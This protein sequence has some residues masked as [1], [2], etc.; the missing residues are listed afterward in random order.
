MQSLAEFL[1]IDIRS[2]LKTLLVKGSDDPVVALVLRGDHELNEIKAAALPDVMAPLTFATEDELRTIAG[3][4]P[5]SIGPVTLTVPVIADRS[6][7]VLSN[8][9][10][11]ANED[12][13]HLINVNWGRDVDEP[14]VAD[15]RNVVEGDPSPCGS[16][17]LNIVRG[18]EVGH[19]FELGLTYSEAMAATILD[20]NGKSVA[21]HMGCYGIGIGRIVAAAIEQNHDQAGIIWPNALSPFEV[22]I[23]PIHMQKSPE[24]EN[25]ATALYQQLQ[26]AGVDVL[27]DDRKARPGVMFAEMELIGIPHRLVLSDRGLTAGTVEYKGRR[28][29]EST[30]LPLDEAAAVIFEKLGIG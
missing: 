26:A 7:A 25:A 1:K 13:K 27:F 14:A 10:C 6:A 17:T 12:D 16:G 30:D 23:S 20:E 21:M 4:S 24:V 2:T 29:E 5:G 3:C 28:D 18:I 22:V 8:F 9:V 15:L 11:G 19:I